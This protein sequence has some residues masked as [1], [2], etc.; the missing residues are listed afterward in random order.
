[1]RVF[2]TKLFS[3]HAKEIGLDDSAL[4]NAAREISQG[5]F[6]ANLGGNITKSALR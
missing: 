3:R 6:E 2:K 1:M 5:S 4:F